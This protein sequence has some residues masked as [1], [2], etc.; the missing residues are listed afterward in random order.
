MKASKRGGG[1]NPQ[2]YGPDGRYSGSGGVLTS[3]RRRRKEIRTGNKKLAQKLYTELT[4]NEGFTMD[5]ATQ[6][7]RK[8]G[9]SVGAK[10]SSPFAFKSPVGQLTSESINQWLRD[11]DVSR[12]LAVPGRKAGGWVSEDIDE[13]SPTFGQKVAY[14]DVVRVFDRSPN[15]RVLADKLGRKKDQIEVADLDEIQR[16][17]KDGNWENTTWS[18]GGTGVP[19]PGRKPAAGKY[20]EQGME[21]RASLRKQVWGYMRPG[22]NKKCKHCNSQG[23]MPDGTGCDKCNASGFLNKSMPAPDPMQVRVADALRQTLSDVVV[24]YF[25]AHGYHW[26]VKGPDFAQYHALFAEIYEDVYGSVDPLA[27]NILKLGGTAPARLSD[28][29]ASS[30]LNDSAAVTTDPLAL[31]RDLAGDNDAVLASL[32]RAFDIANAANE[33]GIANFIAERIDSHQKWGWQLKSSDS[34]TK[35]WGEDDHSKLKPGQKCKECGEVAKSVEERRADLR[36]T[37][38]GDS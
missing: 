35:C 24:M 12:S 37:L 11:P 3:A 28:Y 34:I 1:G 13:S 31:A 22:V 30:S 10:P 36:K 5:A 20:D 4:T 29:L 14:I 17:L 8:S 19:K 33:Q 16:A 18:T 15:N 27:E 32:K 9:Y 23:T 38:K 21:L 26:N 6:R 25:H 7:P 2:N